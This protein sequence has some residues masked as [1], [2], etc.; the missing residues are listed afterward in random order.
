MLS[1]DKKYIKKDPSQTSINEKYNVWHEK[2]TGWDWWQINTA[3]EKKLVN[4]KT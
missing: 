1:R 3:E 4:L 2:Y